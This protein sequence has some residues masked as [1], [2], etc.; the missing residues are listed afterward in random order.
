[1]LRF[2]PSTVRATRGVTAFSRSDALFPQCDQ[3]KHGISILRALGC[4][5]SPKSK[6]VSRSEHRGSTVCSEQASARSASSGCLGTWPTRK[7]VSALSAAHLATPKR[8]M[9]TAGGGGGN[10]QTASGGGDVVPDAIAGAAD[11]AG[12]AAG[13]ADQV[14]CSGSI[15]VLP[16][17]CALAFSSQPNLDCIYIRT[18]VGSLLRAAHLQT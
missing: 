1:M 8:L 15:C 6:S 3:Q 16:Q 18:C 4:A 9:S 2:G 13:T 17:Q 5:E 7:R 12:A 14:R 11:A 10:P